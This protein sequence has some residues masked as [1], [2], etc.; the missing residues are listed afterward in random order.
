[1]PPGCGLQWESAPRRSE[2]AGAG[3]PAGPRRALVGCREVGEGPMLLCG[4]DVLRPTWGQA[5]LGRTGPLRSEVGIC[6]PD[7]MVGAASPAVL[8]AA[9]VPA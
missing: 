3:S 2:H 7:V 4:P 5:L 8:T 9:G 1:M 6:P